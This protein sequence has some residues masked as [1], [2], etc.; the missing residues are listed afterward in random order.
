MGEKSHL[1]NRCQEVSQGSKG[2]RAAEACKDGLDVGSPLEYLDKLLECGKVERVIRCR[3]FLSH[4]V[5][6]SRARRRSGGESSNPER[7]RDLVSC[8]AHAETSAQLDD[9]VFFDDFVVAVVARRR[10]R[11]LV[12]GER[13]CAAEVAPGRFERLAPQSGDRF[14]GRDKVYE[15]VLRACRAE[16]RSWTCRGRD[17]V[18]DGHPARLDV[19]REV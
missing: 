12:D 18:D 14:V 10:R 5:H 17:V 15:L 1:L 4:E 7:L 16:E 19:G 11:A 6:Q 2:E 3:R 13:F 9:V 8:E